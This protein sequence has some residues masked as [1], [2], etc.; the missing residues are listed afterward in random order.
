MGAVGRISRRT[1]LAGALAT[2]V[3]GTAA[4][5]AVAA[6]ARRD[7]EALVETTELRSPDGSL[8]M[9]QI[10]GS[11][12][13]GQAVGNGVR[14]GTPCAL[15]WAAGALRELRPPVPGRAQVRA[16]NNLGLAVGAYS[17]DGEDVWYPVAWRRGRPVRLRACPAPGGVAE[18]VNDRGQ[19]VLRQTPRDGASETRLSLLHGGRHTP[20][21]PPGPVT[22]QFT[23]RGLSERGHVLAGGHGAGARFLW[24]AGTATDLGELDWVAGVNADGQVAGHAGGQPCLWHRGRTALLS[25][26]AG[27]LAAV[28]SGAGRVINDHGDIAGRT[29]VGTDHRAVL[30]RAG[31]RI[32]LGADPGVFCAALAV[33]NRRE[34][35]GHHRGAALWRDGRRI[36][37]DAPPGFEDGTAEWIGADGTVFGTAALPEGEH[38]TLRAVRWTVR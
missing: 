1:V 11:N 3:G 6:G 17:P 18:R 38:L 9:S 19:I 29:S 10:A 26:P 8:S 37:L 36:R 28:S 23:L 20:I 4:A 14:D 15:W 5:P 34:A 33:N 27:A 22:G 12:D 7:G 16:V 30:W 2:A 31:R 24:H 21:T 32:E 13:R 35:V 25:T